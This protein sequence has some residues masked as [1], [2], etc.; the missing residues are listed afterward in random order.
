MAE[1][2]SAPEA[3][4]FPAPLVLPGDDLSWDPK[5]DTQSFKSWLRE[6]DRNPVTDE[7]KVVYV[8]PVPSVAAKVKHVKEWAQPK[9]PTGAAMEAAIARPNHK[10]VVKYLAA[11]YTNLPVKLLSKPKL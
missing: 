7:R 3:S 10:N 8:A 9:V 1:G 11:F 2:N 5:Y 6:P 4:T